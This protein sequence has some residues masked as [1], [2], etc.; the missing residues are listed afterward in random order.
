MLF[1]SAN[2]KSVNCFQLCK[3]KNFANHKLIKLVSFFSLLFNI[4]LFLTC[5][6][7]FTDKYLPGTPLFQQSFLFCSQLFCIILIFYIVVLIDFLSLFSRK[8]ILFRLMLKT[9]ELST[10]PDWWNFCSSQRS[11]VNYSLSAICFFLQT[12]FQVFWSLLSFLVL[13]K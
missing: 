13:C 12:C 2:L 6:F 4:K 9:T 5:A 8:V 10:A 11:F 1:R 3:Q 7:W